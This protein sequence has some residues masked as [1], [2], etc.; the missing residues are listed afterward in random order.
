M[1]NKKKFSNIILKLI[2]FFPSAKTREQ[3]FSPFKTKTILKNSDDN[4]I[5]TNLECLLL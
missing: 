3:H 2:I 4:L 5:I 1:K